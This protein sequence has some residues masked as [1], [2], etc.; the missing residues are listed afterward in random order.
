[1]RAYGEA[2]LMKEFGKIPSDARKMRI[3][4]FLEQRIGK[5]YRGI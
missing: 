3:P 5:V 2:V 1:M 4:L